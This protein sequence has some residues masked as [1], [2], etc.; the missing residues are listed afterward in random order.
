MPP[1]Q[2][3]CTQPEPSFKGLFH[4]LEE[5]PKTMKCAI[6]GLPGVY[7]GICSRTTGL[8]RSSATQQHG[9]TPGTMLFTFPDVIHRW[10]HVV[11]VV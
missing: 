4:T 8:D 9:L 7:T 10:K 5:P 11:W 2:Q 1:Y 6:H 3:G